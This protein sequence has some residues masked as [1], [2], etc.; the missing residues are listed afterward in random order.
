M[1]KKYSLWQVIMFYL[2][3]KYCI[4]ISLYWFISLTATGLVQLV[5]NF[6]LA[7]VSKFC[8]CVRIPSIP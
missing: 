7:N 1:N 2:N 5:T 4:K 8:V 6:Q 3:N